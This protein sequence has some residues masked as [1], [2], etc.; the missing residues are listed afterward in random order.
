MHAR[1]RAFVVTVVAPLALVLT[2]AGCG[3][4]ESIGSLQADDNT[5]AIEV[6]DGDEIEQPASAADTV[7]SESAPND[8]GDADADADSESDSAAGDAE[9][10]DGA[11]SDREPSRYSIV[12]QATS[13]SVTARTTPD[14][15]APAVAEF[16]NPTAT[17]SP[18]V[19]RVV[20]GG[21]ASAEWIEVQLPVQPNGTT[22]WV[23]KEQVSLSDNPYRVEIS[24]A[25][26][27]LRVYHLNEL[28]VETPIAVGNGDTPTP[29]GDFYLLE[30]LQPSDPTG[31]YGPYAFGLSG[32]SE[33]LTSFGGADEA[34]IG[35]HG[36][37][38]PSSLGS[39]VSHGCIRL[40]NDV[41]E[42]FAAVLPLGTPVSIT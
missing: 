13:A 17:G 18:L 26:Y 30:L 35:L 21:T 2:A 24:R 31:P 40:E 6:L 36:T 5:V 42:Q 28:W 7:G 8:D 16:D 10:P 4:T 34:I 25:D 37:N 14:A 15:A 22:G 3:S 32:F 41:I 19:F 39:D 33:V 11:S 27:S 9:S 12:A 20:P 29:V 1:L 23:P 38:D